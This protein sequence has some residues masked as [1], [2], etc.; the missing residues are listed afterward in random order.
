MPK[1]HH[2]AELEVEPSNAALKKKILKEKISARQ[3]KN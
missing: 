2:H 1:A 3:H